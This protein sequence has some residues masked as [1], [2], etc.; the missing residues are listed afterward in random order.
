MHK[1]KYYQIIITALLF[2]LL[3]GT[4]QAGHPLWTFQ[5][6]TQTT[7]AVPENGN[8]TVQYRVTNNSNRTHTL[9]MQSIEGVVQ[10]S[11]GI[12]LCSNPI[13]LY[14]KESCILSLQING[15]RLDTPVTDGP[16]L[17]Q[18]GGNR[19]Q[20]YRPSEP[21]ILH[22]TKASSNSTLTTIRPNAGTINGGTSVILTGSGLS[23]VT[24]VT[25]GGVPAVSFQIVNST[26]I[27]AITPAHSENSVDVGVTTSSAT[28]VLINGYYYVQIGTVIGGGKVACM[29][30]GMEDFIAALQDSTYSNSTSIVWWGGNSIA[31]GTNAQSYTDG[32]RNT[33]A[34][35]STLGNTADYAAAICADY[36]AD[37]L[38]N[39][40]CQPGYACYRDWFLP[41]VQSQLPCLQS[42]KSI[43]GDFFDELYWSSTEYSTGSSDP[44]RASAYD[45]WAL[46]FSNN[47]PSLNN[48]TGGSRV[49]CIR[50]LSID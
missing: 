42:N 39:S 46:D 48:K 34:I 45:A 7:L 25:F 15:S 5:P 38:G 4:A 18:Q 14:S 11:S 8:A 16:I 50:P 1:R 26:T 44:S 20:C 43:L 30:G 3:L 23:G 24:Q 32:A 22:L 13:I 47:Q 12:N 31:V 27:T 28:P 41:A 2:L 10:N 21:D 36:E 29:N 33:E 6:L 17:C 40:P 35:V 9:M 19:N 49:R 37:A